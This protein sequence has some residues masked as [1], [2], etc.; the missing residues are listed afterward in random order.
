MKKF[1]TILLI[2][3]GACSYSVAVYIENQILDGQGKIAQAEK[4]LDQLD[5]TLSLTPYTAPLGRG[6]R[7]HA[8]RK[9]EAGKEQIE[10]YS[11]LEKQLKVIGIAS[12]SLGVILSPFAFRRAKGKNKK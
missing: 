9:I 12:F 7:G 5:S 10:K 1:I 3:G 6:I 4:N 11:D 8:D 2:L